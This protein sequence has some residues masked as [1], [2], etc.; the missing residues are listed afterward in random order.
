MELMFAQ[1]PNCIASKTIIEKFLNGRGYVTHSLTHT[2]TRIDI[3]H[4]PHYSL[5]NTLVILIIGSNCVMLVSDFTQGDVC[6]ALLT[7]MYASRVLSRTYY[8]GFYKNY[9]KLVS[10]SDAF[11]VAFKPM[12]NCV[13]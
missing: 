6:V 11:S 3:L 5:Q 10:L 9:T 1:S 13:T 7:Y 4:I 8:N 12:N 2:H